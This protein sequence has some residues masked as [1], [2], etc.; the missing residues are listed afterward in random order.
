MLRTNRKKFR[1]KLKDTKLWLYKNRTMPVKEMIKALNLKLVGH[2]R[3]YGISFNGKM[4]ANYL[5]KV[6]QFLFKSLNRR[7]DKKSY[8]LDGYIEMLKYYPLAKPKIYS[9]LF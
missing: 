4:I 5:H 2:Y 9:S 8:S 6:Q 3:Y 1:Q 7:S